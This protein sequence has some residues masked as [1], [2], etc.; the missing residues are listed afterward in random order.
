MNMGLVAADAKREYRSVDYRDV[1]PL[2]HPARMVGLLLVLVLAAMFFHMLVVNKNIGWGTVGNYMF[3]KPI[4][5]GLVLTIELTALSMLIGLILGTVIAV[6]RL[7]Q[8]SLLQ[9]VAWGWIT[10]F[11]GVPPLVQL[12]FWYNLAS[13][14]RSISLG[15]P[16]GPSVVS[17]STNSLM[18]PFAAAILGLSLTES[19]YASEM[20]RAGIVAVGKGQVEASQSLGLT[21]AQTLRRIV[22]P[23]AIKIV[24]PPIGNDFIGMLKFTSLVSVLALSDLL[25]SAEVIYSR[26]YQTIPL[27]VVATLWYLV[28]TGGLTFIEHRVERRMSRRRGTKGTRRRLWGRNPWQ[29]ASFGSPG[30]VGIE[31][32]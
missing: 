13:L 14:V 28:L 27:L 11:R 20:I 10:F 1:T 4:L 9:F 22:L 5:E 29:V 7:S 19:A 17:W 24:I 3:A 25:Y 12:L 30:P 18:T 21:P 2:R 16:F 15:V 23:Q 32:L 8:S 26:T 31:G 6:M